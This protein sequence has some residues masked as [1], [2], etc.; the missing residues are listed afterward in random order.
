MKNFIDAFVKYSNL[1]YRTLLFVL[2]IGVIVYFLPREGKF[3]YE[4]QQGAPWMHENLSAP[5]NFPIYKSESDIEEQ[6]DS[7]KANAKA[8]YRLDNKIYQSEKVL[9]KKRLNKIWD[10]YISENTSSSNE[11]GMFKTDSVLILKNTFNNVLLE[12]FDEVYSVGILQSDISNKIKS[13]EWQLIGIIS[14]GVA[15][16]F[17]SGELFTSAK[18]I[19]YISEKI[20][21]GVKNGNILLPPGIDLLNKINISDFIEPNLIFDKEITKKRMQIQLENISLS[22]GMISKGEKIIS[23][24]DIVTPE[25]ARILESLKREYESSFG[26]ISNIYAILFAQILLVFFA[27][28]VLYLFLFNFR[29][30]I[31]K[32]NKKILFILLLIVLFVSL[33]GLSMQIGRIDIYVIPFVLLP[34]IIK[35]FYDA[36]LSIFIHFIAI[37]IV[38]FIAPNG[39]EFIFMQLVAGT[40]AVFALQH[41]NKRSHLFWTSFIVF[42]SYSFVHFAFTILHEGSLYFSNWKDYIWLAGNGLLLL[43]SYPLIYIF[44]KMFAFLSDLTLMELSDTNNPLLRQLSEQAPGTF[45]HS[46]QVANLAEE[47]I[48][49]IGGNSLLIRAGA[50]YHDIGKMKNPHFYIENLVT[51]S[52]PHD[53][54]SFEESADTIISHVTEG[55]KIGKKY[56][57]PKEVID[58]IQMHHGTTRVQYFY[59]S[60]IKKYPEED[61]DISRFSYPGPIPHSRETAVLMMADSVE[62]AS[63]SLSMY[64]EKSISELV[65]NIIHYQRKISITEE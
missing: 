40:I 48:Y 13:D 8:Y 27:F 26:I 16:D 58:F 14:D 38:A 1:F 28:L 53:N 19:R 50:L 44:E 4:F 33:A 31:L 5:F 23:H 59:K 10:K 32:N 57:L 30:D 18:A 51:G 37:T 43:T 35:T 46:L 24:S 65:D 52:N 41:A 2:S 17:E 47:A 11:G 3:K 25:K 62:A 20:N 63:R 39:F 56:N 7:I 36:R 49:Q 9:L 21:E 64:T 42:I 55:V 45:Q 15:E 61:A 34:I 54:L 60:F 6:E 29:K 22:K 12:L